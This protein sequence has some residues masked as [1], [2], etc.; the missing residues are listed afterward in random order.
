MFS[1]HP[2]LTTLPRNAEVHIRLRWHRGLLG[3]P[4]LAPAVV[5]ENRHARR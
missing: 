2:H 4:V 1:L 3:F 5:V